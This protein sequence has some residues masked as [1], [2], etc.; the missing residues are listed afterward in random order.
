[1]GFKL[2]E[3]WINSQNPVAH[4][5]SESNTSCFEID[6][7]R[8]TSTG[9][10]KLGKYFDQ[11]YYKNQFFQGIQWY[12]QNNSA[13]CHFCL[14]MFKMCHLEVSDPVLQISN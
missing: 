9:S 4:Q 8:E 13:L 2:L 5:S 11:N 6:H 3:H 10:V 12:H 1:M 7:F 14:L